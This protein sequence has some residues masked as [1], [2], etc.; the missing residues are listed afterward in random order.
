MTSNCTYAHTASY[1]ASVGPNLFLW[2]ISR[3]LNFGG[4]YAHFVYA[5]KICPARGSCGE[6][7][8]PQGILIAILMPFCF[9]LRASPLRLRASASPR[10]QNFLFMFLS[11]FFPFFH[12][13]LFSIGVNYFVNLSNY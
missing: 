7:S 2:I 13:C 8:E 9:P 10:P 3:L 11:T 6:R 4:S 1:W 12:I 5:L